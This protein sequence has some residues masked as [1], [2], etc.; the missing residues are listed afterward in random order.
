MKLK[1]RFWIALFIVGIFSNMVLPSVNAEIFDIGEKESHISQT[2]TNNFASYY[3][4][5]ALVCTP[6]NYINAISLILDGNLNTGLDQTIPGI[7][8]IDVK[9]IF[10]DDMYINSIT[11]YPN[12]Q[13]NS[14]DY[15]FG[16]HYYGTFDIEV[17]FSGDEFEQGISNKVNNALNILSRETQLY[18][19]GPRDM[20]H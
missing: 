6:H 4:S 2:P 19:I 17:R 7:G 8:N 14:N 16:I 10:P 3:S 18:I 12:F 9:L 13:G 11:F 1:A 5:G 20:R 15:Q